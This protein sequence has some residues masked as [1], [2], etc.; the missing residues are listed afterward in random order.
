MAKNQQKIKLFEDD[1]FFEEEKLLIGDKKQTNQNEPIKVSP[2]LLES[3]LQCPHCLWLYFN[4]GLKRP[5][6]IFPSLPSGVDAVAKNYFD[7]YRKNGELPPEIKDKVEGKLFTDFSLLNPWRTN[8]EGIKA[9]LPEFNILLKG[10]IDELLINKKGE[11]VIF[12]FKTRGFPLKE[13]THKYYQLQMDLYGI[14]F[15]RNN[16]KIADYG[17]LMFIWPKSYKTNNLAL[18]TELIKIKISPD[19]ALNAL[20][21][22]KK[23]IDSNIPEQNPNC[24]YCNF[25]YS[26]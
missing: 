10:A 15:Q 18:N 16:Y 22:A 14:L 9:Y 23:I 6:G 21:E 12:D 20:K 17:Y 7:Q 2:S 4:K 24:V 1:D 25:R 19:N 3:L 13:D 8:W 26:K 5:D 11:F